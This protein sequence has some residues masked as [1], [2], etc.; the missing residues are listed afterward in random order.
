MAVG[1]PWTSEALAASSERGRGCRVEVHT[2]WVEATEGYGGL[3]QS[4]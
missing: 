3:R 4:L 2:W 1:A